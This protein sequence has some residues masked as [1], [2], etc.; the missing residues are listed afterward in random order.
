[1]NNMENLN[2]DEY[3]VDEIISKFSFNIVQM[4]KLESTLNFIYN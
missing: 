4:V 2:L 3:K 1:M